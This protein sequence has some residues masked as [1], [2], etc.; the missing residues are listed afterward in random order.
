MVGDILDLLRRERVVHAD[1]GAAGM[2]DPEVRD[3]VLGYVA[4]HDQ[5]EL[6]RAEAEL[7]ERERDRRH[8]LAIAMPRE[9]LPV[10]VVL[11]AQRGPIAPP[12]L[13]VREDRGDG[14][15]RDRLVDVGS[16]GDYVHLVT[17]SR[18]RRQARPADIH[19][20]SVGVAR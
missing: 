9:R 4:R 16:F 11:P 6:V 3:H 10:A 5:G 7:A 8:L 20:P 14:L 13:G 2:H 12:A 17:P 18:C 1:R 15:A 19:Y